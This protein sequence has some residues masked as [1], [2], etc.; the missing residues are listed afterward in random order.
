[1][2]LNIGAILGGA[3]EQIVDMQEDKIQRVNLLTDKY[4]D[5]HTQN[6]FDKKA[7]EDAK[8]ELVE[9]EIQKLSSFYDGNIDAGAALYNK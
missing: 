9:N 4:W 8:A 7:K 2:A 1:M 6:M 5:Q 3:A